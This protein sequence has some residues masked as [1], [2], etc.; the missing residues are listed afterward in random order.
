ML[1]TETGEGDRIA[2]AT[3]ASKQLKSE[4]SGSYIGKHAK[5]DDRNVLQEDSKRH[6]KRTVP[7]HQSVFTFILYEMERKKL[8]NFDI[9]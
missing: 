1:R 6:L 5:S 7:T 8:F 9:F 4:K 2:S 3:N